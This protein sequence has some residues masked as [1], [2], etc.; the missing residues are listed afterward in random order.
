MRTST[1]A[2]FYYT[3]DG[4][5]STI[6]LTDSAQAAA[7]TYSYDSWGNTTS[8]GAQAATNPWTYAGGYNDTASNRIKF[9]ARYYNPFRGRFTQE[10]PS[11]QGAN[12]YLYAGANPI[13]YGDPS[14][15]FSFGDAVGAVVGL[16]ITTAVVGT[17]CAATVG[18]GCS[19]VAAVTIGAI[20]GGV[21]GLTAR[22]VGAR[23]DGGSNQQVQDAALGGL[24]SGAVTGAL[25]G[26]QRFA[27]DTFRGLF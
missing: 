4:L 24:A 3:M 22:A 8:S 7:A 19:I 17:F 15:L 9:G 1:G 16:A 25:G 23:I 14:G 6:L 27:V 10:D 13:N 2:S 21:G 20:A 5:G 12:S 26:I 18:V 11:G